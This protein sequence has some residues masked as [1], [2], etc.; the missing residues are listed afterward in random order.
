MSESA[1]FMESRRHAENDVQKSD[2]G[3]EVKQEDKKQLI[4]DVW[5]VKVIHETVKK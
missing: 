5:T 2:T 4:R 1:D 3:T